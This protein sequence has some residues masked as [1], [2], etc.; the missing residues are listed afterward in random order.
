MLTQRFLRGRE[1]EVGDEQFAADF[2]NTL[3]PNPTRCWCTHRL[4]RAQEGLAR[5]RRVFKI[6]PT[7]I[8]VSVINPTYTALGRD[9]PALVDWISTPPAT[10]ARFIRGYTKWD[11]SR[12]RA[13]GARA[14]LRATISDHRAEGPGLYLS[15]RRRRRTAVTRRSSCRRSTVPRRQPAD[16]GVSGRGGVQI[17]GPRTPLILMGRVSPQARGV[18]QAG[19]ARRAARPRV[20]TISR[21]GD[22]PTAH[23]STPSAR[24]LRDAEP[25]AVREPTAILADFE[26]MDALAGSAASLR[27]AAGE[28]HPVDADEDGVGLAHQLAGL[29]VT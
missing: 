12:P 6:W 25:R 7:E 2:A 28:D 20:L 21:P 22:L 8:N 11:N 5:V 1:R 17:L 19:D 29:G 3:S 10:S 14:I 23:P 18:G 27:T 13:G 16:P 24:A 9:G 4:H 26:D 15:R